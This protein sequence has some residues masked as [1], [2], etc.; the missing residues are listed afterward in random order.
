M[1]QNKK[2]FETFDSNSK[3]MVFD[4]IK[5]EQPKKTPPSENIED[6]YEY[7]EKV[8]KKKDEEYSGVNGILLGVVIVLVVLFIASIVWG[9]F[10]LNKLYKKEET[11]P[12]A[13]QQEEV[14]EEIVEEEPEE[15]IPPAEEEEK[16]KC[17]IF[18]KSQTVEEEDYG[19]TVRAIFKDEIGEY[20]TERLTVDSETQI[21]EDGDSLSYKNFI[22]NVVEKLEG[23]EVEFSGVVDINT[24]HI[25]LVSYSSEILE[26]QEEGIVLEPEESDVPVEESPAEEI[27]AE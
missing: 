14:I 3:T 6:I 8:E 13:P 25:D 23:R 19:Y 21:K 18:F 11:P 9:T 15:E 2:E 12:P 5:E 27:P 4:P 7:E 20:Y 10:V 22:N 1:E 16:V 26:P 24:N 17:T